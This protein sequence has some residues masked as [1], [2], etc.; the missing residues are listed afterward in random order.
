MQMTQTTK[1]RRFRRVLMAAMLAG[2]FSGGVALAGP[3]AAVPDGPADETIGIDEPCYQLIEGCVDPDPDPVGP[4]LCD[5]KPQI[6]DL[7]AEVPDPDDPTPQPTP[8][9]EV[10]GSDVVTVKPHFT[11]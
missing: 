6:C 11:G 4:T 3:A 9:P 7:T 10:S 2:T 8:D 1:T 5:D